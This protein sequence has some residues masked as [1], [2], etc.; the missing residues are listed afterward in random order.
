VSTDS[1]RHCEHRHVV[2]VRLNDDQAKL[3]AL[4]MKAASVVEG[5]TVTR[6]EALR[7][8][9]TTWGRVGGE[10]GSGE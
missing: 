1:H 2:F 3:L 5:R 4:L 9:L 8:L 6:S 7:G 10:R